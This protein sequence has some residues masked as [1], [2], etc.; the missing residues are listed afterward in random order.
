MDFQSKK[1]MP[2]FSL[3]VLLMSIAGICA[4]GKAI[5]TMTIGRERWVSMKSI[6]V[7]EG[8]TL[9]AKRGNILAADGSIL[10]ASLP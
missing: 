5:Y 2:R 9:P 3:V 8:R 1:I 7:K 6:L 4:L 10:A